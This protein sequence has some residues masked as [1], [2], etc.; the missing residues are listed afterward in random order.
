MLHGDPSSIHFK[1]RK[2]KTRA[3]CIPANAGRLAAEITPYPGYGCR[4]KG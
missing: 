4:E 1:H 3:T 2:N